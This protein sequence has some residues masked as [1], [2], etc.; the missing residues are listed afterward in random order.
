MILTGPGWQMLGIILGWSFV[1]FLGS[2]LWT[3]FRETVRVSQ[4]LHQIP[5]ANCRFCTNSSFLKCTIHP[6]SALT[7]Q[8]IQC[9][10]FCPNA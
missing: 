8:A 7:E 10:D 1:F 3:F 9:P 6:Q 5:C 2:S 4:R